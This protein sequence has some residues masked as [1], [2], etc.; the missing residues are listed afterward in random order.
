MIIPEYRGKEIFK[1]ADIAIPAGGV[2]QSSEEAVGVARDIGTPVVVKAQITAG[3]RGK[4]GFVKGAQSAEEAG[5]FASEM[6]GRTHKGLLIEELLVEES[7]DIKKEMYLSL[8]L[9][10]RSGC[11]VLMFC[12]DGGV[13]IEQIARETPEKLLKWSIPDLSC[14]R[15]FHVRDQLRGMGLRG[16]MLSKVT[17]VAFRLCRTFL[18]SDLMLAEINP[19][20]LLG[21]DRVIAADSKVE[22]DSNALYRHPYLNFSDRDLSDPVEKRGREI[23]VTYIGLE[24]D[25]GIVASGAGLAMNTMDILQDRGLSAANFLETGGGITAA[26]IEN[27][28]NLLLNEDRVRGVI[29]NLY[30]GV[31]PMLAAANGIIAAQKTNIKNIPL[32]VKI[33]GNQQEEAWALVE[34]CNIPMIK[35]PH[36]EEAVDRLVGMLEV[37]S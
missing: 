11:A 28:I 27:A 10:S 14:L 13:E 26:L 19:L 15:E 9:H 23:G 33:L 3:G 35:S 22:V 34:S 36:T 31:N 29:V 17:D 12:A 21:D 24:G 20:V 18:T 8:F 16:T 30:G 5:V 32:V 1:N 6:L 7:L 2:V 25:I 37:R 4:A